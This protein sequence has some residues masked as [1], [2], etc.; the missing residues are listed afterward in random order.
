MKIYSRSAM[1]VQTV[2]MDMEFDNNID[3]L[4]ENVVVKTSATKEHVA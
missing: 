4:M 1:I 2:L 3:N